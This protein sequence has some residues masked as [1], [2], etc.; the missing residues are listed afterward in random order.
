MK[1]KSPVDDWVERCRRADR[2]RAHDRAV[3]RGVPEVPDKVKS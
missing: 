2:Q 3:K 1:R